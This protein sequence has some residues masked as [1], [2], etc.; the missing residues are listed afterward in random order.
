MSHFPILNI[1]NTCFNPKKILKIIWKNHNQ[2]PY[3]VSTLYGYAFVL[4]SACQR[5]KIAS[6]FIFSLT[7]FEVRSTFVAGHW[8]TMKSHLSFAEYFIK[9][10]TFHFFT[11]LWK[12]ISHEAD[13]ECSKCFPCFTVIIR[14][15]NQEYQQTNKPPTPFILQSEKRNLRINFEI[16]R[17]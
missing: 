2:P 16:K 15:G 12:K 7:F 10:F 17:P 4:H 8:R 5:K 13:E 14:R 1:A 3:A 9:L 6:A 11:S